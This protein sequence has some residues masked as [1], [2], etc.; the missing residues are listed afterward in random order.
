VVTI[1]NDTYNGVVSF[2]LEVYRQSDGQLLRTLLASPADLRTQSANTW[3][4]I[5]PSGNTT[6]TPDEMLSM[7]ISGD[8][9]TG[10][11]QLGLDA[12]VDVEVA[13]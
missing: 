9:T 13:P 1:T 3:V 7:V 6:I 8:G 2:Q 11:L 4:T 12:E 10:E 5:T